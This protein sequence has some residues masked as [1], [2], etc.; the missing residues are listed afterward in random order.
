MKTILKTILGLAW[1][2]IFMALCG[3]AES[4]LPTGTII[5]ALAGLLALL[6][7]VSAGLNSLLNSK[8]LAHDVSE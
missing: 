5:L 2:I 3:V 8:N 7:A 4:S 1:W 6:V